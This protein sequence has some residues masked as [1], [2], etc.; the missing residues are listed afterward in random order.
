M[1]KAAL[2][3]VVDRQRLLNDED[4]QLMK[5]VNRQRLLKPI[6]DEVH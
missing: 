6:I 2:T 4:Y 3:K 1:M 5:A